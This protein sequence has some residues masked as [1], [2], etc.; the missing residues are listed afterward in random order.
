MDGHKL[1]VFVAENIPYAIQA[2]KKAFFYEKTLRPAKQGEPD[3][4]KGTSEKTDE[5]LGTWGPVVVLH[6]KNMSM[7]RPKE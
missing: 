2:L 7:W 6:F 5:H 4:L 3:L 1:E